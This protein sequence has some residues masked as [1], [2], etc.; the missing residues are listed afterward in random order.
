MTLPDLP[1]FCPR[2]TCGKG[3]AASVT[4]TRKPSANPSIIIAIDGPAGAGKSTIA[5]MVSERLGIPYLD[6]GAMYRAAGLV[7]RDAGMLPPYRSEDE[8]RLVDLLQQAKLDFEPT[9]DSFRVFINGRD[10]SRAIRTPEAAALA[11]A[12][13]A[14]S[15]VRRILVPIQ[16]RMGE[17][18]GG[19]AEGRD[20]GSVVF[21]DATLKIFLTATPEERAQRR[22]KD[23]LEKGAET[24]LDDVRE[25]QRK[26]DFQD[27]SREDSP[28]QVP[29][30]AV[31]IDSTAMSQEQVVERI[32][33]E[34][35]KRTGNPLDSIG[36]D[37][38][39]SRNYGRL[40][41]SSDTPS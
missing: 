28:L 10:V 34:L 20:I 18:S 35:R 15:A 39:K 27:T 9:A 41:S 33:Q 32:F 4:H 37:A 17:T 38:V 25:A 2:G 11:S 22:W 6:T 26:R 40:A 36:D 14:V 21:P 12:V 23:L 31:V 30:G 19:V 8:E 24:S 1:G 3:T 7:A 29:R 16:R 5:K 13:S